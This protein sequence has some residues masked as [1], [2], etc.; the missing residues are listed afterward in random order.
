M[1]EQAE[2]I[3]VNANGLRLRRNAKGLSQAEMCVALDALG[4]QINRAT[5]SRI[6]SGIV[7][8]TRQAAKAL[9][10]VLG[11]SVKALGKRPKVG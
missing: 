9:A 11:C 6:E 7:Q 4:A 2:R 5:L 3:E 10:S 8:P 1:P